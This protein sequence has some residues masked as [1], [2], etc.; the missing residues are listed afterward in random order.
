MKP[1]N[2]EKQL[3][4]DNTEYKNLATNTFLL[5]FKEIL[6]AL[7]NFFRKFILPTQKIKSL[8]KIF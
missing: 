8:C 1:E 2:I 3:S 5:D 4:K 6:R 7:I